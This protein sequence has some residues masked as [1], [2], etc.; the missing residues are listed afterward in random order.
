MGNTWD[1]KGTKYGPA[2]NR[3]K[4]ALTLEWFLPGDQLSD[5]Y[6]PIDKSADELFAMWLKKVDTSGDIKIDW[7]IPELGE[8]APFQDTEGHDSFFD[9]HNWPTHSDDNARL[10][11]LLLPVKD[12]RWD[13]HGTDK[14]GFIQVVTGWK[15]SAFQRSVH[16]PTLLKACGWS[17]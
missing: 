1:F 15:P 6:T 14:G 7:W 17:S 11:W 16:L 5:D 13:Q 10:N 3:S 4:Q 9:F 2:A 12:K 8:I